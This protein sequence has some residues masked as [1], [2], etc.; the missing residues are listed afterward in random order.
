MNDDQKK[1]YMDEENYKIVTFANNPI[2]VKW[3]K[4]FLCLICSSLN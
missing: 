1:N 2:V 4:Q 3:R